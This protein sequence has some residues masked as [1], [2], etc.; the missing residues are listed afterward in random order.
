MEHL[1]SN[2]KN[3]KESLQQIGSY[4]KTKSVSTNSNNIKDLEGVGKEL[5]YFLSAIYKSH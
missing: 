2:I 3:I 4:I 1:V 5:W